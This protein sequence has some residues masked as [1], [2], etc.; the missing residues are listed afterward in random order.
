MLLVDRYVKE[1]VIY[2]ERFELV[3]GALFLGC[4]LTNR[5][6]L[7]NIDLI[8]HALLG[9]DVGRMVNVVFL[10]QYGLVIAN[11]EDCSLILIN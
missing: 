8:H 2:L 3:C 1:G 6:K 5:C 10:A 11:C 9:F 7:I 4:H